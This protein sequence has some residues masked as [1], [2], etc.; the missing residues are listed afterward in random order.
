MIERTQKILMLECWSYI[1][2]S[3]II[4]V[5]FEMNILESGMW[6]DDG[7]LFFTIAVVMELLLLCLAP[8]ALYLFRIPFIHRRLISDSSK[9]PQQLLFW[10]TV[11]MDMLGLP[12]VF[13][14]LFYYLFGLQ[15]TFGYMA[16]I[17]LL[18]LLLVYPTMN[19][20]LYETGTEIDKH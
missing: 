15:V 17:L 12:M 7:P 13:N 19:R 10:G 6:K 20:C 11:R 14:T 1:I 3:L 16:I 4:V 8:L 2:V 5:L 9:A 18:C